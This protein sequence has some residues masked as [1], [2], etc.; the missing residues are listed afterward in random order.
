MTQP[1]RRNSLGTL[2]AL[3]GLFFLP[4]LAAFYLYYVGGWRPA[5]ATN[6]GELLRP[7]IA[8]PAVNGLLRERWTL[9]YVGDGRCDDDCERALW[10]MRQTRLS[11][12]NDM[13]RVARLFLATSNCCR[14]QFLQRE[15]AGLDVVAADSGDAAGIAAR[16]PVE[17][18][19]KSIFLVDPRGN[20]MMQT[21]AGDDPKGLLE[22][23][24][25]LLK[26]SHIG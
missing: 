1:A 17:A 4:L 24:K 14:E 2:L 7:A 8:L 5:A 26:L 16:F 20:L 23:L 6:H 21:N 9:V 3:F 12:N 18:R 11:L 22:D 13:A 15:H 10:V 25:K 19:G